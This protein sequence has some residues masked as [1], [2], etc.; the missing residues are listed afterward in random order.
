[1]LECGFYPWEV[2]MIMKSHHILLFNISLIVCFY[3]FVKLL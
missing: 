1:M 3:C 2:K